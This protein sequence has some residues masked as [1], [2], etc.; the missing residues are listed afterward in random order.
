M[1]DVVLGAIDR[2]NE[3]VFAAAVELRRQ[4][5]RKTWQNLDTARAHDVLSIIANAVDGPAL[6]RQW[7]Y[8]GTGSGME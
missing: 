1:I 4:F 8:A 5:P 3:V 6:E 7:A 2:R